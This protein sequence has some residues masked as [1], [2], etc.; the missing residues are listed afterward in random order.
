MES[1]KIKNKLTQWRSIENLVFK[2]SGFLAGDR[3][4]DIKLTKRKSKYQ[5]EFRFRITQHIR[6]AHILGA[7]AEYLD[8]GK[9]YIRSTGLA[10]DLVVNNFP[11]NINKTFPF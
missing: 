11:D 6:D 10:C 3:T 7:I 9:V 5:V 2:I 8:Q 1:Q 4:F